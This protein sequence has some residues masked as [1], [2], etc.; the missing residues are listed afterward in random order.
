MRL[1]PLPATFAIVRLDPWTPIPDWL[2]DEPFLSITRT[3]EELS[4]VCAEEPVP[5]D[6]RAERGWRALKLEGPIDFELTGVLHSLLG[7]LAEAKISIFAISTFD[8]D[9]VLVREHSFDRACE[10]LAEAGYEII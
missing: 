4:I 3:E 2:S 9:Y 5:T 6:A 10:A 7:P 8:T 1:S